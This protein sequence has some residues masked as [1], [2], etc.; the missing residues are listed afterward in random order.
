MRDDTL[1]YYGPRH[2]AAADAARKLAV[3]WR[4]HHK[5]PGRRRTTWCV[6]SVPLAILVS[7]V[8]FFG[9]ADAPRVDS[10]TDAATTVE[11]EMSGHAVENVAIINTTSD[12]DVPRSSFNAISNHRGYE[13]FSTNMDV[14]PC[15][16]YR[17][18]V[19]HH[20]LHVKL[21][22]HPLILAI[23][24]PLKPSGYGV[25]RCLPAVPDDNVPFYDATIRVVGVEDFYAA[26]LYSEIRP[27]LP[28]SRV[29]CDPDCGPCSFG[30]V[31]CMFGGDFPSPGR[32]A[33]FPYG[34][35]GKACSSNCCSSSN[36]NKNQIN[37]AGPK[38]TLA[39][40][41]GFL[42]RSRHYDV[43]TQIGILSCLGGVIFGCACLGGYLVSVQRFKSAVA[44]GGIALI[45][46]PYV[47]TAP[48]W[49]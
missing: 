17:T 42:C 25:S 30:T 29:A 40:F 20:G 6:M 33:P 1:P 24:I 47:I 14:A 8:S 4:K 35:S 7:L 46:L 2:R 3:L 19:G 16:G 31:F 39:G 36:C 11:H 38:L 12:C 9:W 23:R 5:R 18:T 48:Y 13:S 49:C 45:G 28:L 34:S 22:P 44:F 10:G 15:A 26:R 21:W 37:Y 41:G 27:Q 43:L 32:S